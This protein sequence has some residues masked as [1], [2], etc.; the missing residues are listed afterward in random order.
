[1][2]RAVTESLPV[3]RA[4]P[5]SSSRACRSKTCSASP[6]TPN[7]R[8][9]CQYEP[10]DKTSARYIVERIESRTERKTACRPMKVSDHLSGHCGFKRNVNL[11]LVLIGVMERLYQ[12]L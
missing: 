7:L 10:R 3:C 1:M 5:T 9:T 2:L 6:V 8:T 12:M 4:A 11:V